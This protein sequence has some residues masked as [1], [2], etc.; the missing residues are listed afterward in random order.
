MPPH[1]VTQRGVSHIAGEGSGRQLQRA[2]GRELSSISNY[3][4][5]LFEPIDAVNYS[6]LANKQDA[7]AEGKVA[8]ANYVLT[9]ELG[10]FRDAAPL[11][12]RTDF[13]TLKSGV[14]FAV[15]SGEEIWSLETP[16]KLERSNHRKYYGLIDDIA[17][18]VAKSIAK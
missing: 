5:V 14:L 3:T 11:T 18:Q 17:K 6:T 13:V 4:I 1:D 9:L 7:L 12:F 8:G 10:E 2:V 15:N 16:L